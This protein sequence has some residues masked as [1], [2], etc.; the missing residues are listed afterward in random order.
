MPN[1][2]GLEDVAR[3]WSALGK[4]ESTGYGIVPLRWSELQS[5]A[6]L[7]NLPLWQTDLIHL[8]SRVFV[9]VYHETKGKKVEPPY[10]VDGYTFPQLAAMAGAQKSMKNQSPM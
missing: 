5:F 10:L 6:Q 8:M 9:Y 4:H 3:Y 7:H 2:D 1:I